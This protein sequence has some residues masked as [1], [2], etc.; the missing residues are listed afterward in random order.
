MC[1]ISAFLSKNANAF[2]YL[3]EALTILQ[4]RG[5]DSAG[6]C[7]IDE[8]N[9]LINTKF[10]STSKK[11]AIELLQSDSIECAH[12]GNFIGI[13]HTRWA[14]HGSKTDNN[15][16]PHLD[17]K[18]R[19]AIVHNGIIENYK[20]LK[21]FLAKEGYAFK[22]ETDTEVIANLISYYLDQGKDCIWDAINLAV[23][24]LEGTWGIAIL[25][26][27]DPDHLYLCKKGSPLLVAHDP[28]NFTI[29][30]SESSVFQ[31]YINR[32]IVLRDNE[33]IR[34]GMDCNEN[35]I[36]YEYQ[37]IVDAENI[38]TTPHPYPHWMLKEIF[39]QPS[40]ILRAMSMGGRIYDDYTVKLGGINSQKDSLLGIENLLIVA[41]GTSYHAALLGVKYFNSL[42][43]FNTVQAIDASEFTLNDIPREK[44]GMIVLSQ[45]GE[46]K[47]VHRAMELAREKNM[48][49]IGIVNTVGSLIARDTDCGVYLNAGRETAVASTK[50]FTSQVVVLI[51]MALWFAQNKEGNGLK[52]KRFQLIREL[53]NL[54]LNFT[55][56]INNISI[57]VP[58]NMIRFLR[59]ASNIFILGKHL[60]YPI[61][62]EAAL[63]IKEVSYIHAEGYSASS[64]KHGTFA[65]IE[66]GTP[67][68]FIIN[69]DEYAERMHSAAEEVKARGAVNI[70]ITNLDKKRINEKI[71]DYL[72]K[73]PGTGNGYL[74]TLLAIL[75]LQYIA[76]KLAVELGYNPDF[77]RNLAKVVTVD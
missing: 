1:G 7:T 5:Y 77:P 75:P 57:G 56:I 21:N 18:E 55:N 19:V 63:K 29:I 14:T 41:C 45:S 53:R 64:L 39:E 70:F 24:R 43:C 35:F 50:S 13:A 16:H 6:I 23:R 61:A 4:N 73:I 30:A 60:S 47:D 46:T 11:N 20:T 8:N 31:K 76:Y 44:F 59:K 52:I 32:Y 69:D 72:I 36:D 71:Y 27:E 40:S 68:I 26:K 33:I 58:D 65:L 17:S 34:V 66:K 28:N 48:I 62:L 2:P 12:K 51:L 25:Y 10:A 22:S 49:I 15:A 3:L 38:E 42:K 37:D 67:I 54:S 9:N 74:T